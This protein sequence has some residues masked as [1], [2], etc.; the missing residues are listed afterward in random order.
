VVEAA[1]RVVL[2]FA[3]EPAHQPAHGIGEKGNSGGE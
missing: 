2:C 1:A 3:I